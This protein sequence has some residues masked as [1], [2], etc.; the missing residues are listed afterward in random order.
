MARFNNAILGSRGFAERSMA[1][2]VDLNQGGQNGR[3]TNIGSYVANA[4]YVRRN[5]IPLLLQ[6]PRGFDDLAEPELYRSTL[7]SLVELQAQSIEGLNATL[8]VEAQETPVGGAGE[9]QQD[10]SNV[11][12]Q[13]SEPSFTWVEKYGSPVRSFLQSWITDLIMDPI[14]KYPRVISRYNRGRVT[15]LL[16]DYYSMTCVF[17]EPDPTHTKVI[18]SWLCTNMF[19]MTSGEITG[20]RDLTQGGQTLQLQVQ[21]SALTQVGAGVD[22]FAQM[23]LDRMALNDMNPNL[24]AA[25]V[26]DVDP[27]VKAAGAGYNQTV[28]LVP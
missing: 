11:T 21:F 18:R 16:P 6:T 10:P 25:F 17:I 20:S 9:Q 15:D 27:D 23:L 7:K 1:P 4:A 22:S 2:M 12:R 19:P 14:T 28:P 5:L 3:F 13:R 26:K 24:H 8:T